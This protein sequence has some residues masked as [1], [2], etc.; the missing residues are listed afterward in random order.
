MRAQAEYLALIYIVSGEYVSHEYLHLRDM[1][2]AVEGHL[3]DL[4]TQRFPSQRQCEEAGKSAASAFAAHMR[5]FAADSN[6]VRH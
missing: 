1:N 3:K 4:E 5:S 2:H 6:R